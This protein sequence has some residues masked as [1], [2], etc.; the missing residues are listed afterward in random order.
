V[1][2]KFFNSEP[3]KNNQD[4]FT[5]ILDW[6]TRPDASECF[7]ED[8]T[9]SG[10]MYRSADGN[11]ACAIGVLMPTKLAR[12]IDGAGGTSDIFTVLDRYPTAKK[13][14]AKCNKDFLCGMQ[15]FHDDIMFKTYSSNSSRLEF[16]KGIA[17][18]YKLKIPKD[19]DTFFS[20]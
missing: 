19:I 16:L 4:A 2:T 13:W 1:K 11:N 5:K 17:N 7:V 9:G 20:K 10:C 12:I 15:Q 14:F 8:A 6:L 3:P 18:T